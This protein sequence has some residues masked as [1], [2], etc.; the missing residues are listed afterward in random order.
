M[1][2]FLQLHSI[3]AADDLPEIDTVVISDVL[4]IDENLS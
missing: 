1:T 2:T 4:S 3:V